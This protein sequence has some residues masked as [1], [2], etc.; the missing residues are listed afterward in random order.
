MAEQ[1]GARQ[2]VA[3]D[4]YAWGVDFVARGNYWNE[5]LANGSLPD[6][7]R[8]LID[9][10]Q[11]ELP[12]RHGFDF[13]KRILDSSAEPLLEDFTTVDLDTLGVFD[14]TLYLGVLYHMKEPLSCLERVR[15]VT[16]EV[17]VIETEAVHLHDLD[18]ASLLD[19]YPGG[20]LREDFSN[21]FVPTIQC[22]HDMCLVAGFTDVRTIKGPPQRS[23]VPV[24][25]RRARIGRRIGRIPREVLESAPNTNYRAVVHAYV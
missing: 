14:V 8:D 20:A 6:P 25:G 19:F 5:C 11:P 15:M 13:A 21:W 16:R 7:R 18:S 2:V 10:W 3:L 22:L 17:A 23:P 9:F 24:E 4:N 1:R 12:G